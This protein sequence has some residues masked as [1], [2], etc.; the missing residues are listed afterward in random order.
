MDCLFQ[1][2]P[3]LGDFQFVKQDFGLAVY[4]VRQDQPGSVGGQPDFQPGADVQD[5]A[6][7]VI[8]MALAAQGS[9]GVG[10]ASPD[11]RYLGGGSMAVGG[12][13]CI[14][15]LAARLGSGCSAFSWREARVLWSVVAS[16][17]SAAYSRASAACSRS[18]ALR[19]DSFALFRRDSASSM[20]SFSWEVCR[21]A[22][23]TASLTVVSARA[24]AEGSY[25]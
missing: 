8:R 1:P 7:V 5:C 2:F 15:V 4:P 11:F 3:N 23:S 12:V 17:S 24:R 9:E 19:M 10:Y 16:C 18:S 13:F 6:Q 14:V 21:R 25:W 20:I 22:S